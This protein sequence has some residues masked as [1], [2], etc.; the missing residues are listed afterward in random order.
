VEYPISYSTV[1]QGKGP[2]VSIIDVGCGYGAFLLTLGRL[3]PGRLAMGLEIR[4][5]V[6]N[7]V[8]EKIRSL[9]VNNPG[10]H[11]NVGVVR[12]NTMR[13]LIQYFPGR[14]L[15][16]IFICFADPHFKAKNF[17]RR[18][19]NPSFI[20]EYAYLL[21]PGGRVHCVTDVED[22]HNWQQA[23]LAESTMFK[24]VTQETEHLPEV[25][26]MMVETD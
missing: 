22:L 13:H 7:Y 12:T 11:D 17:R 23:R 20:A 21:K 15:D 8:A 3:F 25:Q 5:K 2:G 6:V 4:G 16:K 26:A 14:S 19:V 18:V 24:D 1:A 10:Q 9:R